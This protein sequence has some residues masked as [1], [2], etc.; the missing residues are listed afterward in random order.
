MHNAYDQHRRPFGPL[1]DPKANQQSPCQTNRTSAGDAT[2]CTNVSFDDSPTSPRS[3][4]HQSVSDEQQLVTGATS[5]SDIMMVAPRK[6]CHSNHNT[7]KI[8]ATPGANP[9]MLSVSSEAEPRS[10][11]G[12]RLSP[13][14]P[15][16]EELSPRWRSRRRSSYAHETMQ[17]KN[18]DVD[19]EGSGSEDDL[20]IPECARDE[21]YCPSPNQGHGSGDDSDDEQYCHKRRKASGS[22]YSSVRGIPTSA[23]DSRRRKRSTRAVA[24][25]SRERDT[26]AL[27]LFSRASSHARSVPSDASAFLA[28]FHEW[29]LENVSMKRITENGKTTLQFVGGL[30]MSRMYLTSQG[31]L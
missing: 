30:E 16:S 23:R 1:V 24:H 20:D 9:A 2:A 27:G 10:P 4:P 21:E 31:V 11:F 22:P 17:D 7:S 28:Q 26:S 29:Q 13:L 5:K 14:S 8:T 12:A 25:S 18:R 19:I 3:Q 6:A 15:P